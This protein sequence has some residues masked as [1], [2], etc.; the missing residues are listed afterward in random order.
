MALPACASCGRRDPANPANS[1]KEL[2]TIPDEHWL[3][4]APEDIAEIEDMRTVTLVDEEG[5]TREAM[6]K[7]L[8]S[9]YVSAPQEYFHLHPELI[10]R[11]GHDDAYF[12]LCQTCANAMKK[13]HGK[14]PSQ[15]I[16]GGRDYGLLARVAVEE[17]N[18]LEEMLLAEDRT[19]S[20]VVKLHVPH[21]R[22]DASTRKMLRGHMIGF[23]HDGPKEVIKSFDAA[24]INGLLDD[25]QV[26]FVGSEG[27]LTPLEMKALQ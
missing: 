19:Y 22:R 1:K 11:K 3:R 18:A 8:R 27:K 2:N 16:A 17:P 26:V 15:S 6:T 4:I 12:C 20:V 21:M 14:P 25:V 10:A 7:H 5:N 24:R 13:P 9:Y 23:F